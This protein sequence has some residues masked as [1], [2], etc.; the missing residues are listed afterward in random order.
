[1]SPPALEAGRGG[2]GAALGTSTPRLLADGGTRDVR[3]P[4][5]PPPDSCLRPC[6]QV[7]SCEESEHVESSEMSPHAISLEHRARGR[8][9]ALEGRSRQVVRNRYRARDVTMTGTPL[10]PRPA[11]SSSA[12]RVER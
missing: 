4:V 5:R 7:R 2:A 11:Q 12:S 6:C 9:A 1:M 3:L 8:R 10:A